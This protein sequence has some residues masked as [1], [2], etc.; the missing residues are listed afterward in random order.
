MEAIDTPKRRGN[1]KKKMSNRFSTIFF[2]L[3]FYTNH[4]MNSKCI[5]DKGNRDKINQV[6]VNQ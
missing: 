5:P 3:N 4:Q 6:K 1:K 2:P